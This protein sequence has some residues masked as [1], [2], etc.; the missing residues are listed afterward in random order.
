LSPATAEVIVNATTA[1]RTS[2]LL[3]IF[4]SPAS[5]ADDFSIPLY[6]RRSPTLRMSKKCRL[7]IAKLFSP[8]G[9]PS[10][11]LVRTF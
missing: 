3:F 2:N 1:I 7:Q 10:A 5:V 8:A 9:N 11:A 6:L 4:V